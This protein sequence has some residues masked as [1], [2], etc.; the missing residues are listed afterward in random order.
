MS[1]SESCVPSGRRSHG[2]GVSGP[3][4]Q[5]V[6]A[7]FCAFLYIW[8][9]RKQEQSGER[10]AGSRLTVNHRQSGTYREDDTSTSVHFLS[11]GGDPWTSSMHAGCHSRRM[12]SFS[13]T[14]PFP[15]LTL[16]CHTPHPTPLHHLLHIYPA[17]RASLFRGHTHTHTQSGHT[18]TLVHEHTPVT[19]LFLWFAISGKLRG[20]SSSRWLLQPKK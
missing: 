7:L 19:L 5:Q 6:C 10:A 4:A 17:C 13:S 18:R 8:R 16:N 15:P 3:R 9:K 1:G 12:T 14:M 2:H 20:Q 11:P